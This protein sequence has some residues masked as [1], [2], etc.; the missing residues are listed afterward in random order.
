[1]KRCNMINIFDIKK[2]IVSTFVY[3]CVKVRISVCADWF[4]PNK[5]IY[6]TRSSLGDPLFVPQYLVIHSRQPILYRGPKIY[7]D[8]PKEIK[9]LNNSES[10]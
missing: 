10:F 9:L 3:K 6:R 2:Y 4:R 7:N 5:N 1:M 8:I